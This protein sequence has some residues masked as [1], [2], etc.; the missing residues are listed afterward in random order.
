M[1]IKL[2]IYDFTEPG[3]WYEFRLVTTM[4]R[5]VTLHSSKNNN[6]TSMYTF[7]LKM[8]HTNFFM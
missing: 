4:L 1:K 5:N 7:C 3:E 8:I 6:V 2:L